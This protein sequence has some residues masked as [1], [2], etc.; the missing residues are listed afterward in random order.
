[1]SELPSKSSSCRGRKSFQ[2]VRT[3]KEA[4]P[5]SLASTAFSPCSTCSSGCTWADVL[6]E[7]EE[8]RA[9]S[10]DSTGTTRTGRSLQ[11]F[12][13]IDGHVDEHGVPAQ[14]VLMQEGITTYMVQNL[15]RTMTRRRFIDTLD[16]QGFEG[17][18]DFVHLPKTFGT[19]KNKGFAFINF[20]SEEAAQAFAAQFAS[21]TGARTN[22]SSWRIAPADVQGFHAN[23]AAAGSRKMTRVRNNSCRPLL[24]S[25]QPAA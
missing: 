7:T 21:S 17:L 15:P 25:Q 13:A 2:D 4:S 19:G 22:D 5:Q 12:E 11:L 14:D 16:A 10:P 20:V 8:V 6:D 24:L 18:Y 1:V 23:A 9:A 3:G